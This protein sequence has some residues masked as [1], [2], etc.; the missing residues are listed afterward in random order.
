VERE[1]TI[2]LKEMMAMTKLMMGLEVTR[3]GL[4]VD[5]MR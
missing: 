5:E 3:C 2:T 4:E 1:E